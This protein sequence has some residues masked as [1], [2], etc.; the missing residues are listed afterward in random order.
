MFIYMAA[1][2]FHVDNLQDVF[3]WLC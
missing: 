3:V 1:N 2:F